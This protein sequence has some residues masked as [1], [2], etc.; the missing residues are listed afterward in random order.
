MEQNKTYIIIL[1]VT[2]VSAGIIAAGL[3]LFSPE[4]RLADADP[5][6]E[7]S[8]NFDPFL[9]LRS[10]EGTQADDPVSG[11]DGAGGSEGELDGSASDGSQEQADAQ[12]EDGMPLVFRQQQVY[13]QVANRDDGSAESS[14]RRAD[15][16][17]GYQQQVSAAQNNMPGSSGESASPVHQ[18]GNQ[19]AAP[20]AAQQGAAPHGA[21]TAGSSRE[22]GP[23]RSSAVSAAGSA[24][25]DAEKPSVRENAVMQV[26]EYWIQV[27]A[28][29][30][31]ESVTRVREEL[32]SHGFGGR[33]S[34]L[35]TGERL[36]YRLRYGPF[37]VK[38][39]AEKFLEWLHN[40]PNYS[41][42]YISLEYRQ[43]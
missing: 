7:N 38:A 43:R 35:N 29:P 25:E 23:S 8:E 21:S 27:F 18:S 6:F 28:S 10:P 33:I 36:F 1:I 32:L 4:D 34:T 22:S 40:V 5:G 24:G 42:S 9:Y 3:F 41:T 17:A 30:S 15:E 26:E 14:A 20:A 12:P 11:E 39:E 16:P 2:L 19:A 31:I 13:G 37:E